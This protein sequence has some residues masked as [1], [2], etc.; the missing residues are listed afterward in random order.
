MS[1]V[2]S[3]G[4]RKCDGLDVLDAHRIAYGGDVRC[5]ALL[6]ILSVLR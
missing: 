5:I 1:M 4:R 2:A 3:H 6:C